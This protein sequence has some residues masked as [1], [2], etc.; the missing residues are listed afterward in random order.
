MLPQALLL[1]IAHSLALSLASAMRIA[2]ERN[3]AGHEITWDDV[4]EVIALNDS[5]RREFEQHR[6]KPG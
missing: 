5:L 1:H 2:A 4:D 6:A 3:S